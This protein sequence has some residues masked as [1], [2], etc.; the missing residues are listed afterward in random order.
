MKG[1]NSGGNENNYW[2]RKYIRPTY[3]IF[4]EIDQLPF[5]ELNGSRNVKRIKVKILLDQCDFIPVSKLSN[6]SEDYGS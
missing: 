6:T 3:Y 1:S 2:R 4:E 5:K